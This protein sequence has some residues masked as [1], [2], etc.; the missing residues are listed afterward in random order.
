MVKLGEVCDVERGGSPRPINKY[1]TNDEDG[2]NW[3]KIGD[4]PENSMYITSTKQKITKEGMKKSRYV[5][6]G[7]FLLSNSMSFGKPYILKIDGCIHDGW[8][9]LR[10]KC[11]LF[12][13]EYLYYALSSKSV[14]ERF[15]NLAVGGVVN[16]LNSSVVK[17]VLIPLPPLTVQKQ[18][19]KTL[20]TVSELLSLR[21]QQ[22]AELDSL[23]K[24]IF[25]DMFG[26]PV[27]NDKGWE[28]KKLSDCC[29]VNPSKKEIDYFTDDLEVSFISMASVS[30][31][32]DINTNEIRKYREVKT[33]FT[34]FYENDVLFAKI[35]P[36]MENGKGAIARG[37][38]N[39]IGFG[40]TEF[41]VL[42]PK[43]GL[44]NSEWL[45]HL[46]TLPIFRTSAEKNMTGSAGQKRVPASFFDKFR[47]PLPPFSLQTKFADRITQIQTQKNLVKRAI[48]ETQLLFD[49]LMSQYFD[50]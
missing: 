21:K 6:P 30:E 15:K 38:K 40:S 14:Y 39:H 24:A 19:A 18:I 23:T 16:N 31:N 49:S 1:L 17:E 35:T 28:L 50:E 37:L 36:C 27:I 20:D 45:Y 11:N 2:V 32:G 25:Y 29:C 12:H 34:Y 8:L 33:G 48:E 41:H 3:I 7:D 43:K 22:L 13:K 9:V 47:V 5:L 4:A 26:D 42:R 44:S 46:T 10:D